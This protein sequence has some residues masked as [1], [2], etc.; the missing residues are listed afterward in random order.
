MLRQVL[1]YTLHSLN[2]ICTLL[3]TQEAKTLSNY[4]QEGEKEKEE[5]VHEPEALCCALLGSFPGNL[6]AS[7]QGI[8]LWVALCQC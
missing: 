8:T 5:K 1:E 3:E 7:V 2:F 6:I 4:I